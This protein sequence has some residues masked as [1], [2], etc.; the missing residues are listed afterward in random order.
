[1]WQYAQSIADDEDRDPTTPN[2]KKVDKEKVEKT[3]QKINK[4]IRGNDKV[5]SRIKAKARYIE[6]NFPANLE[7]Y[8]KKRKNALPFH[9][10][11]LH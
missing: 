2:F 7:K 5:N 8:E 6:K 10:D 3:A 1:M 4:I 11:K 9:R